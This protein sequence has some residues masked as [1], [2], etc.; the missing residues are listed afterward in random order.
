MTDVRPGDLLLTRSSKGE[1]AKAIR[2]GEAILDDP[3]TVNHVIIVQKRD[4]AG[5]LWGIEGRPGGVGWVDLHNHLDSPWTINNVGQQKNNE[6][7]KRIT[8]LAKTLL[9]EPYDWVGIGLDVM[10]A[11]HADSLWASD[12][13]GPEA[14]AH[15][16][17]SSFADYVY[18]K[19]GLETPKADRLCMP[20]DWARLIIENGWSRS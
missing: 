17:C 4:N 8:Q 13:W 7:R 6:Q 3:N 1:G 19:I 10:R 11:I 15:V 2:I 5:R 16:V 9:G 12:Q 20:S 14:P 18:E